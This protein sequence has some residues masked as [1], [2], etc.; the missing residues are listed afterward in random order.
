M[1]RTFIFLLSLWA[2]S[3]FSARA[4]ETFPL[5]FARPAE[6]EARPL[7]SPLSAVPVAQQEVNEQFDP[8][9]D[10]TPRVPWRWFTFQQ[11][12]VVLLPL[13]GL[14][15]AAGQRVLDVLRQHSV[16]QPVEVVDT[17]LFQ[18]EE[19]VDILSAYNPAWILGP[20]RPAVAA[21]LAGQGADWP[22]LLLASHCPESV[23]RCVPLIPSLQQTFLH[24]AP[25]LLQQ[26]SLLIADQHRW[27]QIPD[28]QRAALSRR[29]FQIQLISPYDVDRSLQQ[30][31]NITASY[32]RIAWLRRQ[33]SHSVVAYPRV[34]QDFAHI[35]LYTTAEQAYQVAML[36]RYWGLETDL[37]W[38]PAV[39]PSY[40]Q[41]AHQLDVWPPMTAW[42]YPFLFSK[43]QHYV[44]LGIF[45]ALAESAA[46]IL[47][48]RPSEQRMRLPVGWFESD[49]QGWR[50][51]LKPIHLE[52]VRVK[53]S[54]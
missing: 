26:R 21:Q 31:L 23:R 8:L 48:A 24:Q 35:V 34:R 37:V 28:E 7:S 53:A 38:F 6:Q 36:M 39:M 41:L 40:G 16:F 30:A 43:N 49:D 25:K 44:H 4:V 9:S 11:P 17:A 20:L 33:L 18:P 22:M 46:K 15:G 32:D 51:R 13:S 45:H 10:G 2:L 1:N 50:I 19:L 52:A 12:Y 29:V 3:A 27:R 5:N 14:Y 54:N 47:T 42:L